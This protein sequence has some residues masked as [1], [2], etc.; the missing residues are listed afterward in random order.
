MAMLTD[1]N[2]HA[3]SVQNVIAANTKFAIS[4]KSRPPLSYTKSQLRDTVVSL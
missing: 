4:A 3:N 2:K 1:L